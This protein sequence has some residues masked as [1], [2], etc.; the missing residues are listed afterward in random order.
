MASAHVQD[1]VGEHVAAVFVLGELDLVDGDEVGAHIHRHRFHRADKIARGGRVDP[2]LAG[3][4]RGSG[5]T[6][7][8]DDTVIHFAREQAQ[9]QADHAGTMREHP[10]DR[11]VGLAGIGGAEDG[12]QGGHV[13]EGVGTARA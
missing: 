4:Q 2:L 1:A 10:L 7:G 11:I 13:R 9:G 3:Q 5:I 12:L 8:G 6:L